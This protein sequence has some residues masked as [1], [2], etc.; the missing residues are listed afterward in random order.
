MSG[1]I[2]SVKLRLAFSV[3]RLYLVYQP[4]IDLATHRVVGAEALLRWRREGRAVRAARSVSSRSPSNPG[5]MVPIGDWVTRCALQFL[6]RLVD[7]GQHD[8][9]M[10]INVSHIQ[11]R[12]PDYVQR[13]GDLIRTTGVS[14]RNIEIE[15]TE[16]V[17]IDNIEL[18][19]KKLSEIPRDWRLDLD[20]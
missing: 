19:E 3:E 9:R 10:A 1:C 12:E 20:R 18:I 8:F 17:A 13:L 5:L 16:S 14:A 2:C 7:H 6:K 15:L 4:F 11:F